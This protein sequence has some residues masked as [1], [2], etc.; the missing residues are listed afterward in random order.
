MSALT[1][2]RRLLRNMGSLFTLQG[3]NYILPL[4]TLPYLVRVLG[5]EKFGIIAFAQAFVQYFVVATDYGFNLSATRDVAV[6]RD[7]AERLGQIVSAVMAIK[8]ALLLA[9]A[10]ILSAL[11]STIPEFRH[12][13]SLYLVVY[14]A[15]IG[16][17]LFPTWL[18]QGLER[19]REITW[20]NMAG[21]AITTASIFI[22]VRGPQDF[23]IAAG[24][25]SA[26]VLIAAVP[27]WLAMRKT[28]T[29]RWI[30]PGKRAITEQLEHGWH[31]FLSTAA[32]NVYTS[33]NTFVLGLI[34]GPVAV[35]Y[36][37]AANK[38]IQAIQGL[39][40]PITQTLYPHISKLAAQSKDRALGFIRKMLRYLALVGI[41]ISL[42]VL[43][44]AGPIVH[45][46]LGQRYNHAVVILRFLAFLPFL[47]VLSNVYGIQT[48]LTLG[49][50][51]TFSRIL[52]TSAAFNFIIVIPLTWRFAADG[53]AIS[54]LATEIFV[55]ITMGVILHLRGV[56]LYRLQPEP[57]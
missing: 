22:F 40:T 47:I 43:V 37:S 35:G 9:G 14:V 26:P 4:L 31:V 52:V 42:A 30:T 45:L 53:T 24:L 33:S 5:P 38:L 15:V 32:I 20:M 10:I 7:D 1:D 16:T 18:F 13:W 21:R 46:V 39:M 36:F 44:G 3:V 28:G 8:L 48:M 50:N 12:E 23:V 56:D 19:M 57:V 6:H 49:M 11:V 27:A 41:G 51:K 29:V 2:R 34:A 25:Q 54:M 17:T 55:T